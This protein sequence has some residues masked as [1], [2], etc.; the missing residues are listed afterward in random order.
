MTTLFPYGNVIANGIRLATIIGLPHLDDATGIR[1]HV[2]IRASNPVGY[3]G[4]GP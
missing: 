4:Q 1:D 2:A 3:R